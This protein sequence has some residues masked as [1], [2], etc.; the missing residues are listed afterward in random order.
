[1]GISDALVDV[2][3][4]E[5]ESDVEPDDIEEFESEAV[6]E[7]IELSVLMVL[8]V[9]ELTVLELS[10]LELSVLV[11]DAEEVVVELSAELSAVVGDA[12]EAVI[13]LELDVSAVS[14]GASPGAKAAASDGLLTAST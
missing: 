3:S 13:E 1:M 11:G 14:S 2:I 4:T 6:I 10:V 8:S 9:L 12:E 5:S 7:G